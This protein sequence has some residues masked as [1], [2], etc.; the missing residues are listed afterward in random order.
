MRALSAVIVVCLVAATGASP[1]RAASPDGH[2]ACA[3]LADRHPALPAVA[4]ARH[5]APLVASRASAPAPTP[6]FIVAAAPPQPARPS[7]T[8]VAEVTRVGDPRGV[9]RL[10]PRSARGPPVR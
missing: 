5:G 2:E 7:P 1:A 9:A 8:T 4:A 6:P 10:T 3:R